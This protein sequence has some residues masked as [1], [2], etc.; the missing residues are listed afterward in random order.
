MQQMT[1]A[2][3]IEASWEEALQDELVKPYLHELVSFLKKEY[4]SGIDIYPPKN[5]I[6]NAFE[7][8]PFDKVKVLIIGQ[9]PYHGPNQ[10]HGLCFSVNKGIKA[11]PSLVNI[12]KE[13]NAD[14]GIPFP[15]HGC[16]LSWAQQGVMLLNTTLTVQSGKPLSHARRGWEQFTDAV[17]MRLAARNDPVV[18]VLWGRSAQQKLECLK[19]PSILSKHVILKAA[20]PSPLSAHNGFMG[21]RHFSAINKE[22]KLLG[23]NPINWQII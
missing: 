9:D 11:P 20:H 10:A 23:K 1:P 14:L 6:F 19:D 13:L 16:L 22:L 5:L 4:A 21:C 18:F 3:K 12:F 15:T 8:T 2:F 7:Q 17:V